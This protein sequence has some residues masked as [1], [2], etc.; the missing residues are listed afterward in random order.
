VRELLDLKQLRESD[1]TECG[2]RLPVARRFIRQWSEDRRWSEELPRAG[3]A[4]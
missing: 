3:T 4:P 2:V 1:L